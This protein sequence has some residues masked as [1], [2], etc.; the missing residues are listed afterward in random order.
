VAA[1]PPGAAEAARSSPSAGIAPVQT[2]VLVAASSV[3][4]VI[5]HGSLHSPSH[6]RAMHERVSVGRDV[7]SQ[8]LRARQGKA[9]GTPMSSTAAIHALAA[10]G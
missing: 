10:A 3:G 4:S 2:S 6:P 7:F 1:C 9:D 5:S 8:L